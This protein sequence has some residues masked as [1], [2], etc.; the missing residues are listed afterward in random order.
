MLNGDGVRVPLPVHG[1]TGLPRETVRRLFELG[2]AK[3]NVSTDLKHTLLDATYE[4]LNN[5][6]DE[7]NPGRLDKSV[8]SA[9]MQK[10]GESIDLLG[11]VGNG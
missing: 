3:F 8:K 5:N 6:R 4:Y 2:G 7:Y 11:C 9:V 1:G 10:V